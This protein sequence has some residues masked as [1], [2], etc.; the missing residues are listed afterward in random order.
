MK[1]IHM[2]VYMKTNVVY[3][4]NRYF[5]VLIWNIA[6]SST[7]DR[8]FFL[9]VFPLVSLRSTREKTYN[10]YHSGNIHRSSISTYE[11]TY[12]SSFYFVF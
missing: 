6:G 5:Y 7:R 1:A 10:F 11:R 12:Y 8:I 9:Y 3:G 2:C 4:R